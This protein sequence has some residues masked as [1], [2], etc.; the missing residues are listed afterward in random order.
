MRTLLNSP[1]LIRLVID[2]AKDFAIFLLD[3]DG[4][5]ASWNVGAS[6]IFGWSD[7]DVLGQHFSMLFTQ[8]DR[9]LGTP[10]KEL[11]LTVEDGR[12]S[13]TRWHVR[14]DGRLF[15][16]D[17]VTTA[18][19]DDEGVLLGFSKIARDITERVNTERRL[20]AQLAL[21][22]VLNAEQPFADTS[23]RLMQA[24]CENL[25]WDIGA[26]WKA[27]AEAGV[28]R[29]IDHWSAPDV[30]PVAAETLVSVREL[31]RG[32]GL[33]GRVWQAAEPLWIVNF[34][35]DPTMPRARLAEAAGMRAGLAFPILH[36]GKVT[37]VM[38][39]F[40]R[41]PR[42]PD[43]AL[44]PVMSLIG[45]QIG[46][47]IERRKTG[48]ELAAS[49]M[50]F[51][52]ITQTAQDAIITIDSD[53]IILFVNPAAERMFGWSGEEM[54]GRNLDMIIPERLR[55]S[56]RR[57][58]ERYLRTKRRNIPWQGVEL[59]AM[60]RDG[61]EFP[62]ELSFGEFSD[63]D[64]TRRFS[65]FARDVSER[66]A[67]AAELRAALEHE[68]QA[69]AEAEAAREQL[70]RRADE[71][72]SFRH[73]ASALTGAVEME[74][75]LNEI[76]NRATLVTRA[77][78]VYVERILANGQVEVVSSL[79]RGAPVRGTRADYPG[80]MTEEILRNRQPIIIAD[81]RGVGASMAPYL[82]RT[83]A[84][85]EVL[86]TPLVAEDEALGALVLLNSRSS[87]R[88]F[89]GGEVIR[90]KTL[91]DLASLALRRVRLMEQEREAREKAETAVRVRDETL[92]IVS[93][94]L[95]NPLTTIALSAE[96]LVDAPAGQGHEHIEAIRAAARQMQRLIQDLLDVARVESGRLSVQ[97]AL[98]DPAMVARQACEWNTPIAAR[99][100]LRLHCEVEDLPKVH[101]DRE[102]LVQV[103]GNLIGN[104]IKFTPEG[105]TVTVRGSHRNGQ[106]VFQVRDTGSGIPESDLHRVFRPYWQAKKTAHMG[107][108]LGLAIVRGIVE[109]H[110]GTVSASNSSEGGALFTFVLPA[111]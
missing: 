23:R 17:G 6:R 89:R 3:P 2:E 41:L 68:Q 93:H 104:A 26:V 86:V 109:A 42:E 94:D 19:R 48:E 72:E 103:F 98:I 11:A 92:G 20:A 27:D 97:K 40:S 28:L 34:S 111:A 59:P 95:R 106:I 70:E 33:P 91:G 99:K 8:S 10:Q 105:G 88:T 18:L 21:T 25:G 102:R 5:I 1:A 66:N 100:N 71:E 74:D 63:A 80:S 107:A 32:A 62:I 46:D 82:T 22:N 52:V 96:L 49:E 54:R 58:L 61:H 30:E 53:S 43:Q 78:G 36:E 57:G 35:T 12:A 77:D 37:G 45:S 81:M 38:E 87:G 56:H 50:R 64:G 31:R 60:H 108:G 44:M 75:V 67:A 15:F 16:A 13:D 24:V 101:A 39:F 69:R 83:C 65:G 90:A 55:E 85:C 47:F 4:N 14:N 76:T 29:P 73:L 51:R 7:D 110:G 79:G 84:D 9:E